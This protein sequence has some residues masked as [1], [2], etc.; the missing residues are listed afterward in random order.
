MN[1]HK[2]LSLWNLTKEHRNLMSQ[3]YDYE[4]GEVNEIV[5]AK[6]DMVDQTIERKC[7][8]VSKYIRHLESEQREIDSFINDM[9]ERKAAYLNEIQRYRDYLKN[10]MKSQGITEIKCPFFTIKLK[11]NP[12]G[13]DIIN[14]SEIPEEFMR[15]REVVK[16][17]I[18]PDRNAIKEE[19]LRTGIQVQGAYVSQ[20]DKLD[21]LIDK[22]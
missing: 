18:K 21:I 7:I 2:E 12:Y 9:E 8:S 5:Q 14:E 4:T 10:N 13:T 22:V 11:K 6:I 15:K 20:K 1:S 3:L 16:T 17:E 19:V